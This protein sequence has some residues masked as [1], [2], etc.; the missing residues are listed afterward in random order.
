M[1]RNS[2]SKY[3]KN[4]ITKLCYEF[5][6]PSWVM[7]INNPPS[8]LMCIQSFLHRVLYYIWHVDMKEPCIKE[9]IFFST[10]VNNNNALKPIWEKIPEEDRVIWGSDFIFSET[11]IS[12]YSFLFFFSFLKIY[13]GLSK[14]EKLVAREY[15]Y[16]FINILG[17]YKVIGNL[18]KRNKNKIKLVIMAN[19]HS[20]VNQCII[21]NCIKYGIKTLYIQ[22]ASVN[23]EFPPNRFS[24]S[25][26]DGL[27]SCRKYLSIREFTGK[28]FLSGSTRFDT[29]KN[30][31]YLSKYVGIA[32]NT[33]D[34]FDKIFSLCRYLV[35]HDINNIIMR[36]HP[37][38]ELKIYEIEKIRNLGIELSDSKT[39]NPFSFI[40]KLKLLISNESS[41]HLEALLMHVP[42]VQFNFST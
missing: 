4:K 29:L 41:I 27:D 14:K 19:D 11:K 28:A 39:E 8:L 40:A 33:M 13:G 5:F 2:F 17:Y 15:N 1:E 42:S 37:R 22:H 34:D 36:P 24:Y 25:F 12:I 31:V 9:L 23:D 35:E 21:E 7:K 16:W 3:E 6:S 38:L 10:S 26:L 30:Q 20:P 18:L 32:I